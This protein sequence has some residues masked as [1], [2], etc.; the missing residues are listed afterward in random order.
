MIEVIKVPLIG[1]FL[2]SV[3]SRL[4]QPKKG[5]LVG[6]SSGAAVSAALEFM[7][8]EEKRR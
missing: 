8:R 7:A 6:I 3:A 5:L 1:R 2:F 4:W